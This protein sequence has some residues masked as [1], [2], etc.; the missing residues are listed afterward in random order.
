M[1]R[2]FVEHPF[3][4]IIAI[5]LG[6]IISLQTLVYRGFCVAEQRWL[7][8]EELF[9]IAMRN[10]FDNYPPQRF[11]IPGVYAKKI[12]RPI[13]YRDYNDFIRRN[14]DCCSMSKTGWKGITVGFSH[15]LTGYSAGFVRVEFAA[16][17]D[18]LP[19]ED[20]ARIL[21][22]FSSSFEH[23]INEKNLSYVPIENCGEVWRGF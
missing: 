14:P 16:D 4:T 5:I 3:L 8:E 17:A 20:K 19:A 1:I 13:Q 9:D 2:W 18:E 15:R 10:V 11:R 21:S 22:R 23:K 12:E 6:G 7:G